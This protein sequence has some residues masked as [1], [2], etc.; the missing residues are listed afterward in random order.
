[1]L[2]IHGNIKIFR[3]IFTLLSLIFAVPAL[4][5]VSMCANRM[6][7]RYSMHLVL[8]ILL[9]IAMDV[10][11]QYIWDPLMLLPALCNVRENPLLP[12]PGDAAFYYEVF[13]LSTTLNIPFFAACFLERHQAVQSPGSRWLLPKFVRHI[14]FVVIIII[15]IAMYES[16][17]MVALLFFEVYLIMQTL[18]PRWPNIAVT[19]AKCF[20]RVPFVFF[21]LLGVGGLVVCTVVT[22]MVS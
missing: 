20:E 11:L 12:I 9:G 15:V 4:I 14:A 19:R 18:I 6:S 21:T 10:V 8:I 22:A 16:Y 7:K 17:R 13:T 2:Q 1:T 3:H 5:I